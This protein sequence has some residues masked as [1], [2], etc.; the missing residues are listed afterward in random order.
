[1]TKVM[2]MILT[3]I[4]F[5]FKSIDE[6]NFKYIDTQIRVNVSEFKEKKEIYEKKNY[7]NGESKE[8]IAE[9]IDRYLNSTLKGKGTF[10]T[11]YSL[12]V[13]MD[14]YLAAGVMLQETGCYWT[15][16]YLT[17]VCNNVGGNKGTPSCNGGSY[18]K[19]NTI[20]EGIKFAINKLNSYYSKG[21]TTTEQIGPYYASDPKWSTR[22]NNYIKKL[23]Q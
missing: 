8:Q 12:E 6:D 21:K 5:Q 19:F 18:R 1:M 23:K 15:C 4:S 10:I 9:K 22:V 20:E 14:P 13:G 16:S 17:R 11:E 7:F 2:F 3:L